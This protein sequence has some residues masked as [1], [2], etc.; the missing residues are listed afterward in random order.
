MNAVILSDNKITF[1]CEFCC[2]ERK[3]RSIFWKDLAF[4]GTFWQ[5]LANLLEVAQINGH[6]V[7]RTLLGKLLN[8][9]QTIVKV[10]EKVAKYWQKVASKPNLTGCTVL[11]YP[12]SDKIADVC[13]PKFWPNVLRSRKYFRVL[14]LNIQLFFFNIFNQY[15]N[16]NKFQNEE[17][18]PDKVGNSEWSLVEQTAEPLQFFF[19]FNSDLKKYQKKCNG[20]KRDFDMLTHSF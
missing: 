17:H 16:R 10:W 12:F 11:S 1:S 19:C 18:T 3:N 14:Y 6:D 7:V 5:H 4:E 20:W 8:S 13:V 2:F 15:W 9:W